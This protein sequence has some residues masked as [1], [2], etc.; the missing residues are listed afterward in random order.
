[1]ATLEARLIAVVQRIRDQFNAIKPRLIPS[2]GAAGQVLAK[3][4]VSDSDVQWIDPPAGGGADLSTY[5]PLNSPALTGTPTT[6]TVV[7]KSDS[8]TTI[9]STAFVQAAITLAGDNNKWIDTYAVDNKIASK[10]PVGLSFFCGGKPL[11][12]E[13]IA[14]GVVPYISGGFIVNN[15]GFDAASCQVVAGSAATASTTFIIKKNGAQVG[16][17]VFGAGATAGVVTFS[18]T[19]KTKNDLITVHAPATPDATLADIAGL[20]SEAR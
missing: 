6:P 9:A 20:L 16:T 7:N 8:S 12:N 11:A 2:G 17:I 5:A 13:V 15:V 3:A 14:S 18:Q 19:S 4:S 10:R 1:M